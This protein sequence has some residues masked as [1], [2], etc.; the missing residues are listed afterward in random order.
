M[1]FP[2][3]YWDIIFL[4][5]VTSLILLVTSELLSPYYGKLN[6]VINKN[7]IKNVATTLSI[8][9]VVTLVMRISSLAIL[10]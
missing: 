5:A 1:T 6:L 4:L 10:P 8:L 3:D 7:K 9:F 2:I